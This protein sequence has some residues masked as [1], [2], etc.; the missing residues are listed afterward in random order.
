MPIA[1]FF[2]KKFLANAKKRAIG[3]ILVL[4]VDQFTLVIVI[5]TTYYNFKMAKKTPAA[6]S[7]R[8]S[9]TNR[10]VYLTPQIEKQAKRREGLCPSLL[11]ND[12]RLSQSKNSNGTAACTKSYQTNTK[13]LSPVIQD[14]E[15]DAE[16]LQ[17][18]TNSINKYLGKIVD[19]KK[20]KS[21]L[22]SI[23]FKPKGCTWLLEINQ[24]IGAPSYMITIVL[25]AKGEGNGITTFVVDTNLVGK[26][27]D[28]ITSTSLPGFREAKGVLEFTALAVR[29]GVVRCEFPVFPEGLKGKTFRSIYQ[30]NARVSIGRYG[31][32]WNKGIQNQYNFQLSIRAV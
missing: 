3:K 30:L 8:S 23:K 16:E 14:L 1:E 24:D 15:S 17:Y 4:P 5:T 13:Y 32:E 27:N 25:Y 11:H 21:D 22:V 29:K 7:K 12:E 28:T 26:S 2:S 10:E 20:K 19:E 9:S 6:P 18:I 31:Y